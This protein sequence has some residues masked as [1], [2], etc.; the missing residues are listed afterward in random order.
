[1]SRIMSSTFAMNSAMDAA[2]TVETEPRKSTHRSLPCK[3]LFLTHDLRVNATSTERPLV[4]EATA[5]TKSDYTFRRVASF[6]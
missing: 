3:P 4:L 1:M 6:V 2:T 5:T